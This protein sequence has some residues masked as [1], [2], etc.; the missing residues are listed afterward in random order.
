MALKQIDRDTVQ[1]NG[2]RGAPGRTAMGIV[3]D[4]AAE[5]ELRLAALEEG[6]PAADQRLSAV[7][8]RLEVVS[9]SLQAQAE[10]ISERFTAADLA[11]QLESASRQSGDDDLL[12]LLSQMIGR[13]QLI[14]GNFDNFQERTSGTLQQQEVYTADMWNC[15]C[16]GAGATCNWGIGTVPFGEI[17]GARHYLGFNVVA[18]VTAAWMGQKIERVE[19]LANGKSTFSFWM[20]CNV[21][22]NKIGLRLMQNF[23][24]G[25]SAAVTVESAE[26]KTLGAAFQKFTV[27]FDMPSVAGKVLGSTTDYLYLVIDLN[28]AGYGGQL[29]GQVGLFELA[30]AQLERGSIAH[31]FVRRE[32][33][34]ELLLCQRHW[35]K[36][37][38]LGV[39]PGAASTFGRCGEFVNAT[40][41]GASAY[42][43]KWAVR[44]RSTPSVAIYASETGAVNQVSQDNGTGVT[45][46]SITS[47]GE[48]GCQ[49]TYSNGSGRYGASFH[50][51]A[52]ARI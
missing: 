42:L 5:T 40:R 20:R 41:N 44:K 10:T 47:S 49:I 37:Y 28:G 12:A 17:P 29:A 18:G 21:A 34:V 36:S 48:T 33:A 2:K 30:Q 7:E 23:G 32:P 43:I 11:L 27:V 16:L 1:P 39:Y 8:G 31:P 19:T 24:N 38:D 52:N 26:L 3:N 13:N 15:A 51:V 4:N 22:G 9:D 14:N 45:V 46:N 25:G 50:Y 6:G 35:E